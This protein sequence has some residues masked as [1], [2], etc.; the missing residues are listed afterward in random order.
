MHRQAYRDKVQESVK[1]DLGALG[2]VVWQSGIKE[3]E[4][5]KTRKDGTK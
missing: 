4:D 2:M 3:I 1:E 5:D